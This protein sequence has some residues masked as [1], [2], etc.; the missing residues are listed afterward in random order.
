MSPHHPQL[1]YNRAHALRQLGRPTE[2][3]A[4]IEQAVA[5]NNG[6]PEIQYERGLIQLTL[7]EFG[8][9]WS[10]YEWRWQTREFA[11]QRRDFLSPLWLGREPLSGK[12]IV[13]H[14]EQGFGDTFQFSRYL[15]LVG[16]L[17]AHVVLEVPPEL[18]T[19]MAGTAQT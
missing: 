6:D 4:S 2:A 14:A 1:L 17:G 8:A 19:L 10:R 16:G 5:S 3:L 15:P 18:K 12:T 9:G 13:L 11:S 7:G